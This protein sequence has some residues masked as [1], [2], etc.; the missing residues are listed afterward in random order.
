MIGGI[1]DLEKGG[2]RGGGGCPIFYTCGPITDEEG[3]LKGWT[4]QP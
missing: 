4:L 3:R 1:L 2:V